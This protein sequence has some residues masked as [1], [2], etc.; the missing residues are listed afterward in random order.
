MRAIG[1]RLCRAAPAWTTSLQ[2]SR[3]MRTASLDPDTADAE[4]GPLIGE[5]CPMC[6]RCHWRAM[7]LRSS[8]ELHR[9]PACRGQCSIHRCPTCIAVTT[10]L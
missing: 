6:C 2:Y 9:Q 5:Y 3:Q 4:A 7:Q 10:C 8:V 1:G